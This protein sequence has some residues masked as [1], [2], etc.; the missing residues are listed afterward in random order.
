MQRPSFRLQLLRLLLRV[1]APILLRLVLQ[2]LLLRRGG[3]H[4]LPQLQQ[5]SALSLQHGR[6]IC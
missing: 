6:G 5:H 1:L 2:Q 3:R 4:L